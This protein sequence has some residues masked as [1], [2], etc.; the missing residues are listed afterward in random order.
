MSVNPWQEAVTNLEQVAK[1]I[2]L[3]TEVLRIIEKPDRVLEVKLVIRKDDGSYAVFTGFRSQ[4]NNARGP[5][6]GGIRFHPQVTKEE[7]MALSLWM[8]L[9]CAVVGI[10]YGGGKGG[11]I[12]DP[13]KLSSTELERLSRAYARAIAPIIGADKDV[14]APDVNT[15]GQIM[16]WMVDEYSQLKGKLELAAFTGKPL[17]F[18]GSQGRT[19]ATGRGGVDIL[20][21]LAKYYHLK[22]GE[23]KVAVQGFGNVGTWFAY[24]AQKEGYKVVAVSD[25]KGT[26]YNPQGLDVKEVMK[27]KKEKGSVV[28]ASGKKLG[29]DE[30]LTLP[31]DVL[32]PAAL[33]GAINE[34]NAQ[35]IKAKYIIEMANGP[36]TVEAEEILLKRGVRIIPDVLS[37]AGGVTV[38]YFEWVQNRQGYYWPK[39]EVFAKLE[40]IMTQAFQDMMVQVEKRGLT[41]RQAAYANALSKISAAIRQRYAK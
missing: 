16:A 24:F 35:S 39:D 23:T 5:Y 15:N 2:N 6:K 21:N 4:H 38:S 33:E 13:H 19:E 18:G 28:Y 30:V 32:V 36:T 26:I 22:P 14:P 11:V 3:D 10:P 40:K 29:R 25:S 9:K 20:N 7:V 1:L 34:D 8:T 27:L 31:V 17:D 37:N 41:H 12:V